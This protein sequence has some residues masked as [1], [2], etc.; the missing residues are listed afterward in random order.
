MT[1]EL[2]R[3]N[4]SDVVS[5]DLCVSCGACESV[6]KS[7][8][9]SWKFVHGLFIPQIDSEICS[10][11]GR[12]RKVCPSADVDVEQTYGCLDLSRK[13][14]DCYISFSKNPEIRQRSASGGVVS[15]IVFELL[16]KHIYD[17][18]YVLEYENFNGG[19]A[20]IKPIWNAEDVLKSARSK[21]IP[22][23]IDIVVSDIANGKIGKS[24]VVCTPCQLLAIKRSLTLY[25]IPEN[26]ILFIG[27]F[28]ENTLNYNIFNYYKH[29]Y[30]NYHFLHFKDKCPNG[31]PGDTLLGK[32]GESVVID[33]SVRMSLKPYFKLPR[34]LF[35]FDKLNQLADIS[36]GDCYIKG[37]ED[38]K[39]KSNIIIRTNNGQEAFQICKDSLESVKIDYSAIA[40]SQQIE[41]K[42]VAISRCI[43][44][45]HVFKNFSQ[46]ELCKITVDGSYES[47]VKRLSIGAKLSD[48]DPITPIEK[49]NYFNNWSKTARRVK[50]VRNVFHHK[51][52]KLKIL[53]DNAG[54][55]NKGA[56]LMLISVIQQIQN[57]LPNAQ[58]VLPKDIFYQNV[59]FCAR[60]HIIP[61]HKPS[62]IIKR[63]T[64]TFIYKNLLN[65][66][67]YVEPAQIDVVLDAG[68]F[69]FSDQW[70]P[71]K[72][73]VTQK[74]KYYSSFTK[75]GRK[76][77]FLPQ[78]FGPFEEKES[79][80]LI[81]IVY[82]YAD[83]IFA[84]ENTSLGYLTR[85]FPY[86]LKVK[87]APDFTCLCNATG[88]SHIILEPGY[89]LIIPNSR[90]ISHTNPSLSNSYF[91]YLINIIQYLDDLGERV[92][93]LNHEGADDEQILRN[94]N[95][96][97]SNKFPLL[98]NL[99]ALEVKRI[100]KD[101][102]LLISSR[103]HGVVSGL[104]QNV[105][106]LCTSWSHKYQELLKEHKCEGN[107]LSIN[108]LE[109]DKAL[110]EAALQ[111]PGDYASKEGCTRKIKDAT[112]RMWEEIFS[113][114]NN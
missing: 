2:K 41:S 94:I 3:C 57:R 22:A 105:P 45:Q 89:V 97:F 104:T 11:C 106:T 72:Y 73:I 17:K 51:D 7:G 114:I 88:P 42:R 31:W 53:I 100:I 36:C 50:R 1:G 111:S 92:F 39:G 18:A 30:G 98:T 81:A 85:L 49:I 102:K 84:R 70:K 62:H 38:T 76:I 95:S 35:C 78:A 34:C 43:N 40:T 86:S 25:H 65:R 58:I 108:N 93:L 71:T 46:D 107:I 29:K 14:A 28:C 74:E 19:R 44:H 80:D 20:Q 52:N 101:S 110:I 26:N 63:K 56:G 55:V 96:C 68:G 61:L 5:S 9:I 37:E 69:Q 15:T 79:K 27:L 67:W 91:H 77:I 109:E 90:M 12:C 32:D 48:T 82:K 103:F 87:L 75:K 47:E 113:K 99:D 64:Y 60:N 54:F 16:K 13:E 21:Y 33:R 24:I 83:S 4:I 6:C 8:S 23:S 10:T 112:E 66:N 59:S